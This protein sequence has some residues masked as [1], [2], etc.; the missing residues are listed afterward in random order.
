[1]RTWFRRTEVRR[2]VLL[3]LG[4]LL[5]YNVNLREI[6]S[7][8]T[9][10]TRLLPAI[11]VLEHRLYLD[12]FFRN[13]PAGAD[14]PY[15]AQRVGGHYLSS[16]PILPALLAVPIY[17]APV[18]L[19]GAESWTLVNLLSKVSATVLAALSVLVV[20]LALRELVRGSSAVWVT[21]VY[22]FGTS[23]W[24]VASQGLWGHGPAQL[25][26]AAA[27]YAALRGD[28]D[29]RLLRNVGLAA[30]LMVAS[31]PVT[32]LLA[33]ALLAYAF[34]R[35]RREGLWGALLFG[36]VTLTV[37]WH[38]LSSFGS[39]AGGY[40]ELHATHASRHG[41]EGVLA[42]PLGEGLLGLLLSPN[43]GLLVYSPVLVFAVAGMLLAASSRRRRFLY[44]LAAGCV[45]SLLMLAKYSVWW[46]GHSYGP[47]L[48][49]DFLP[50]LVLFLGPVAERFQRARLVG[51][52]FGALLALSVAVQAIG[53]FYYPSPRDVDWN[54][55]PTDVDFAHERLWDWQD[56]QIVR[57]L[58][59]GPSPVGFGLPAG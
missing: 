19:L 7:G 9:A 56:T 24:S 21:L 43:R 35:D 50:A 36:T 22:A 46:G 20:Y 27:L 38:N 10:G 42:T 44:Y 18:Y 55:S 58:R 59:N 28:S 40:A 29:P 17:A 30:G 23:T 37:V 47:R 13:Y 5:V 14:L 33:I 32:G 26:L 41:V 48:P 6:S 2:G 8:D 11:I 15:W 1:M 25:F 51:A 53:A 39:L 45:A 3:F 31:R 12:S 57:L 34:H 16:Y 54:T 4:S 52:A 49:T